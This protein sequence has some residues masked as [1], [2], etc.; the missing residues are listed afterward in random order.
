MKARHLSR[1][2]WT[3]LLI[4]GAA[5]VLLLLLVPNA[6]ASSHSAERSFSVPWAAPGGEVEVTV[7]VSGYGTVGQLV[8]TLPAGFAYQ[9]SNLYD[10]A[11]E[12][13]G[14]TVYF[15]LYRDDSVVYTVSAP[16]TEGPYTFS[17]ILK[18][19]HREERAVEGLTTISFGP[20]PTPTPTPE[21]TATPTPIPTPAST[22]GPTL[23]PEPTATPTPTFTPEPTDTPTP[24]PTAAPTATPEAT[25]TPVPEPVEQGGLPEWAGVALALG[26][27]AA[28]AVIAAAIAARRRRTR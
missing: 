25:A 26:A 27:L 2:G 7:A 1:S 28:L 5:A 14:Q 13:D 20:P 12:V 11:V 15:T 18:D 24:T 10:A 6:W 23:T 21:P 8:E 19:E 4:G 22:P 9:R 17:G 3:A 16:E